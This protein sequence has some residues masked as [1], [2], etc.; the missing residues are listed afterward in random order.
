[1]K[2]NPVAEVRSSI[3]L[4]GADRTLVFNCN[5]MVA[6]E[7]VSGKFFL[8]VVSD[9]LS[10]AYP[11]GV[12]KAVVKSPYEILSKV[13]MSDLRALLWAAMHEYDEND[14]PVWPLKLHQVGRLLT[15]PDIIPAFT[16]FLRGQTANNPTSSEMGESQAEK[17]KMKPTEA[18]PITQETGGERGIELPV[19]AFA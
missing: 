4:G 14:D 10:A 15:L 3:R 2:L 17:E 18:P 16:I 8:H 12:E 13:S 11:Q 6:F 5:T 19:D 1:M 7:Q 9:L